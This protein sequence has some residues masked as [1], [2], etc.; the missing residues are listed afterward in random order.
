MLH[1][2]RQARK[3]EF[4]INAPNSNYISITEGIYLIIASFIL[5]FI[6]KIERSDL[7]ILNKFKF[8]IYTQSEIFLK[9]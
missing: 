8:C 2:R 3:N 6:L 4:D 5:W 7:S 1:E 9:E